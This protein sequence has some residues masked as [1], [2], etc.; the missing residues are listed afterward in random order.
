MVPGMNRAM[1]SAITS[2]ADASLGTIW[3]TA[4]YFQNETN[5]EIV[6]NTIAEGPLAGYTRWT[7]YLNRRRMQRTFRYSIGLDDQQASH[8]LVF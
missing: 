6:T 7:W 8:L 1:V 4:N 3:D 2:Y 5:S